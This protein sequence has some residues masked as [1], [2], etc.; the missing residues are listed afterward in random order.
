MRFFFRKKD[1]PKAAPP[2]QKNVITMTGRDFSIFDGDSIPLKFWLPESIETMMNEM[3]SKFDTSNSDMYRQILFGH[4]Y[5]R[6]D[7]NGLLERNDHR[8]AL[9]GRVLFSVKATSPALPGGLP[10][11]ASAPKEKSVA[12]V[13][14]WVPSRMKHDLQMLA[15]RNGVRLSE[16]VR[17]VV[18]EQLLGNLPYDKNITRAVP[19]NSAAQDDE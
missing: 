16:Y 5:G 6:Y 4:L 15:D 17:A 8:F 9:N 14:V 11:S 2:R 18:V 1:E 10:D 7:L 19:Q 12:D 3:S 13:K